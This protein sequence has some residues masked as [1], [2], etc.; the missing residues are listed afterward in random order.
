MTVAKYPHNITL[1]QKNAVVAMF[2]IIIIVIK[3]IPNHFAANATLD[4]QI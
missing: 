3:V 2:L 4:Y 1:S